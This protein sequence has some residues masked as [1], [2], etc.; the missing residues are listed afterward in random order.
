MARQVDRLSAVFVKGCTTPGRYADGH[1]L[2]LS[3]DDEGRKRWVFLYTVNGKRREMGLGSAR[4][5]SLKTARLARDEARQKLRAGIDPL[6]ERR[7]AIARPA[8]GPFA[9]DYIKAQAPGWKNAKHLAQW[10]MTLSCE[11]DEAGKLMDSGYCLSLRKRPVDAID[12]EDVLRVLRPIW[13][14]KP[15]T[16][17]RLRG[18]IE[19]VLD[20]AKAKGLRA[21]EN[22]A[23]WRGHLDKLLPKAVKLSRGHHAAMPYSDVPAFVGKL[24]TATGTAALALEFAILT[25]ARSGEVRGATWAEIDL[26]AALWTI[27]AARMKAGRIHVVPLSARAVAVLEAA[28]RLCGSEEDALIFPSLAKR[29]AALSDMA[30]QAVMKRHGASEFTAHGFRSSFRD[31]AGDRTGFEREV[32]EAALAHAVGDA[33]ERAYRRGSA[34][35]KRC[36]LMEAW[37]AFL[38]N[39]DGAKVIPLKSA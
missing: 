33:T 36:K 1:G 2:Y 11:R 27:P 18:R 15:E 31:W 12:T 38:A 14:E 22:P 24:R 34:L 37:A 20:A 32:A 3:V 19:A 25:A 10:R 21:G 39:A 35:E 6:A 26:E 16:A 17:A 7:A 28:A 9:E 5:V 8:F 23:R 4:E 13:G 29:G 30:F